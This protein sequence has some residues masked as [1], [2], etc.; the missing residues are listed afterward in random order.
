M[1]ETAYTKELYTA[2]ER[3]L[4]QSET[5]VDFF[6]QL[7]FA[8]FAEEGLVLV[9][10]QHPHIR[11]LQGDYFKQMITKQE[12]VSTSV[13]ESLQTLEYIGYPIAL[14]ADGENSHLF[15]HVDGERI[16]LYR[17]S[18]GKWMGKQ[19]EV[20]LTTEEL[21]ETAKENP[22]RLSNNVVTRPI[23]QE[24]LF[25]TLS[26]IGGDGEISYWAV[27]KKAFHIFD[28]NMPPVLPR[29]SFTYIDARTNRMLEELAIPSETVINYGVGGYK[30]NWLAAQQ[31]PPVDILAEQ[32]K[33]TI[34]LAH[35]PF[36][37]VARTIRSDIGDM[38]EENLRIIHREI[39]YL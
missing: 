17:T 24:L 10:S 38:A 21:L 32:L 8:L 12:E 14:D 29:L 34:H 30:G 13:Y 28:I 9:D 31:H 25:P 36:K 6:S 37:D 33:E 7:I 1:N 19:A 5:Y 20:V 26:F 16:L 39:D 3:C 18:D 23:M 27:L 22:E 11:Q 35:E 15:Y 4:Q 2:I